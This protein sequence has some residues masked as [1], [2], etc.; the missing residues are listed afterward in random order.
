MP[1]RSYQWPLGMQP[2]HR[3][4]GGP[5]YFRLSVTSLECEKLFQV[6]EQPRRSDPT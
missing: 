2:V 6:V 1:P 3:D 5:G 4:K